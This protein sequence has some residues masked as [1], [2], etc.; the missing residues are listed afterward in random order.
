MSV[1]PE[2]DTVEQLRTY[3]R[4][5]GLDGK[6]LFLTGDRQALEAYGLPIT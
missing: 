3:L 5:Q 6:M 2:R 1:D 4:A